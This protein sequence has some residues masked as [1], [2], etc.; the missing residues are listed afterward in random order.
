[1]SRAAPAPEHSAVTRARDL[2]GAAAGALLDL[3]LPRHCAACARAVETGA[4]DAICGACWARLALLPQP[5]CARCGH[6]LDAGPVGRGPAAIRLCRWCDLLPPWVRAVRSVCWVS[7]GT[8]GELVHALKYAGWTSVASGM[9]ARMAR[10]PW[11]EDVVAERAALV[12]VP[13]SPV[14]LRER[15]FNQSALLAQ[16]LAAH[17]RVPVWPDA[18]VR[19]RATRSQ[20]RLT[21]GERLRNVAGAFG[22]ADAARA[23]LRGAHVVLVDDVVTTSA[24]L[25][26]CAAALV[27]GGARIV[28]F[29]TFG[30]ARA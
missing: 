2:L 9:A 6:P 19:V 15:G 3:L 17:W 7:E 26:A 23:R 4:D 28:S 27:D 18:V 21:P 11:P 12:P 16:A 29:V 13:L 14:R 30:R 1:V 22:M 20:T 10:L 5:Q 24:T 25:N 8:G